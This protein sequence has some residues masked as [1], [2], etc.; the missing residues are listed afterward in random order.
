MNAPFSE[1][2]SETCRTRNITILKPKTCTM[3][4]TQHLNNIRKL[5]T[6]K[7]PNILIENAIDRNYFGTPEND[8]LNT[9]LMSIIDKIK[10]LEN[11]IKNKIK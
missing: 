1:S 9:Q 8:G 10:S 2:I 5:S 6:K 7:R 4:T 11:A 3:N